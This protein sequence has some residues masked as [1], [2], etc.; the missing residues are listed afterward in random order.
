MECDRDKMAGIVAS[1]LPYSA[2]KLLYNVVF[3]TAVTKRSISLISLQFVD[4][5][6]CAENLESLFL[7]KL[8]NILVQSAFLFRL[9]FLH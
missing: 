2:Q 5:I 9:G 7:N 4:V 3:W 8:Q 6:K 1:N